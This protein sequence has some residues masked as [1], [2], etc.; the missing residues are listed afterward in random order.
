MHAMGHFSEKLNKQEKSFFLDLMDKYRRGKAPLRSDMDVLK[1]WGVRF[2]E[3][4]LLDQT[5][6]SPYPDELLDI[7]DSGKGRD[8]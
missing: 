5:F 8:Y 1:S 7:S 4:Y 3:K 2:G 6:F